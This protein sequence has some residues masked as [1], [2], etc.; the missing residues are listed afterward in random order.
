M[1]SDFRT[2]GTPRCFLIGYKLHFWRRGSVRKLDSQA[3]LQLSCAS[4]LELGIS[5]VKCSVEIHKEQFLL[6][7]SDRVY[8]R[9]NLQNQ[10]I[11]EVFKV[12]WGFQQPGLVKGIPT[13]GRGIELNDL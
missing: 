7:K 9:K 13:H 6:D 4:Q 3:G 5:T 8:I 12:G 2:S 1:I 10:Y 11:F